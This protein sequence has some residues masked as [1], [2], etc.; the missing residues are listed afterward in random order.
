MGIPILKAVQD[1]RYFKACSKSALLK[2]HQKSSMLVHKRPCI[3]CPDTR[4]QAGV[5]RCTIKKALL[6]KFG[7][8]SFKSQ[9]DRELARPLGHLAELQSSQHR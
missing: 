3:A 1:T 8:S 4:P 2:S 7:S 9:K 5:P 6:E